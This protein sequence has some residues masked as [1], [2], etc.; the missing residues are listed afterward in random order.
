MAYGIIR[1]QNL[2]MGQLDAAQ[3]HNLREFEP[4]EF[5]DNINPDLAYK[6]R[7]YFY[8]EDSNSIKEAVQNHMREMDVKGV[9]KNSVVALEFVCAINDQSPWEKNIYSEQGF[10]DKTRDWLEKEYGGKVVHQSMHMDESNPHCHYIFVPTKE[11]E[12]AWGTKNKATGEKI[13]GTRIE[14]RLNAREI[15]GGPKLLSQMQDKWFEWLQRA[16]SKRLE[17][18]FYRGLKA[19]E[20]KKVYEKET[21]AAIAEY[22]KLFKMENRVKE[23][24]IHHS[25]APKILKER[26]SVL[27]PDAS[28]EE[29]FEEAA[30]VPGG[31]KVYQEAKE[32]LQPVDLMKEHEAKEKIRESKE[33]LHQAI[34]TEQKRK[35]NNKEEKW[36]KGWNPFKGR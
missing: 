5:P 22:R 34:K 2:K 3:K 24:I 14:T 20:S 33:K 4:E 13:T 26:I 9:R 29:I 16:W 30:S 23:A 6:N 7:S 36:M 19:S 8:Q 25:N 21:N 31:A 18:T 17:L 11:K 15:T 10:F 32:N 12:I 35:D 28:L 1:V 27:A